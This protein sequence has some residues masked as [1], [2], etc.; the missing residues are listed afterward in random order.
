MKDPT[1]SGKSGLLEWVYTWLFLSI[2]K[3]YIV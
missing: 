2:F 1:L 3:V